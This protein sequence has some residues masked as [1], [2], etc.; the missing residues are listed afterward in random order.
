MRTYQNHKGGSSS[1]PGTRVIQ[2][3]FTSTANPVEEQ[4]TY[5]NP[6]DT[7]VQPHPANEQ[8]VEN[9]VHQETVQ[10]TEQIHQDA[11][12][13][14]KKVLGAEGDLRS[15]VGLK[16]MQRANIEAEKFIVSMKEE[17]LPV[18]A[19]AERDKRIELQTEALTEVILKRMEFESIY[20]RGTD[21]YK[22]AREYVMDCIKK[23][24]EEKN[25]PIF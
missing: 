4:T 5:V 7:V 10:M 25:K 2:G 14:M 22:V 21:Q 1:D 17:G 20:E 15:S 16:A 23:I 19:A 24:V 3:D 6:S 9:V 8:P 18:T 11:A 12:K 13:A